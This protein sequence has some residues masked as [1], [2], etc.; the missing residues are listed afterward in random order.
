MTTV[1]RKHIIAAIE[2]AGI[3]RPKDEADLDFMEKQLEKL[4]TVIKAK[5]AA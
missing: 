4:S 1:A 3:L 2:V 5:R